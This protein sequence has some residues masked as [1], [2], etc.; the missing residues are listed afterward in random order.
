MSRF[1][2]VFAAIGAIAFVMPA[3]AADYGDV[4][5]MRSGYETEWDMSDAGDPLDFEFGM[6]YFYSLG[7]TQITSAGNNYNTNDTSHILELHGRIDDHST[8]T[9]L[10]GHAGFSAF[11]SGNHNTPNT[12]GDVAIDSNS[13]AYATVDFGYLGYGNDGFRFGPF[14]GYQ[15][16]NGSSE[17]VVPAETIAAEYHMFRLGIAAHADLGD[18]FDI[19]AEVA[20]IPYANLSGTITG[21][22]V[23]DASLLGITGEAMLGYHATDNITIRGGGRIWY[24]TDTFGA[25]G[26]TSHATLRGG[27][28]LELTYGF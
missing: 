8:G 19:S 18:Q 24:L 1:I 10:K 16:T 27:A 3:H 15:Y 26:N 13:L 5:E 17:T 7:A 11:S 25:A 6:R 20:V 28:L 21:G 14:I 9:Y 23:L 2:P 22:T 4:P 12:G